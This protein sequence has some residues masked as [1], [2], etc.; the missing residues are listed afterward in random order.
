MAARVLC[1]LVALYRPAIQHPRFPSSNPSLSPLSPTYASVHPSP[2]ATWYIGALDTPVMSWSDMRIHN[3]PAD[4]GYHRARHQH[5]QYACPHS[6]R[7]A[8]IPSHHVWQRLSGVLR[9][10]CWVSL[11]ES[12]ILS[13]DRCLYPVDQRGLYHVQRRHLQPD[14]QGLFGVLLVCPLEPA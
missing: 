6:V 2:C 13:G 12:S 4:G 5:R 11:A 14:V 7:H 10:C 9:S 3:H 1:S 8:D